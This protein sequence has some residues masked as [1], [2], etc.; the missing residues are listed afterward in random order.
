VLT[1][2]QALDIARTWIAATDSR[3]Q[4]DEA[5]TIVRPYGW[6]FV[7]RPVS[8]RITGGVVGLL[9][10]RVDGT[11]LPLGGGSV[12]EWSL[13]RYEAGLSSAKLALPPEFPTGAATNP[14]AFG[15]IDPGLPVDPRVLQMTLVEMYR[16][17][18]PDAPCRRFGPG[19]S[20]PGAA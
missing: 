6:V 9:L 18:G 4:V 13:A 17:S 20:G 1:Y 12:L 3:C 11:Q 14:G 7:V 8:G 10:D 16:A 19:S 2:Q 5:E 15:L